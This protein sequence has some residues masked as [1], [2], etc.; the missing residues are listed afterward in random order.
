MP[1]GGKR[2]P[3]SSSPYKTA[4]GR[5]LEL[6]K[7]S[8]STNAAAPVLSSSEAVRG[9]RARVFV[10]SF[11]CFPN[12]ACASFRVSEIGVFPRCF[13]NGVAGWLAG[14]LADSQSI[15]FRSTVPN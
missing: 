6:L 4:D 1:R 13:P 3:D 11:F 8:A 2:K 14:W 7:S 5:D 10:T 9:G 15:D 12:L